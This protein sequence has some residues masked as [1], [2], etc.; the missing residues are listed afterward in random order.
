MGQ[1]EWQFVGGDEAVMDKYPKRQS[2][3]L[4]VPSHP[5]EIN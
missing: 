3:F 5:N 1:P 2:C 4:V